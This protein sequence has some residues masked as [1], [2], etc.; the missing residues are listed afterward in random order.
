MLWWITLPTRGAETNGPIRFISTNRFFGG[1]LTV[2]VFAITNKDVL[3]Y[4]LVR[5]AA[6]PMGTSYRLPLI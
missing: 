1:E 4:E 5:T 2:R 3:R 6:R